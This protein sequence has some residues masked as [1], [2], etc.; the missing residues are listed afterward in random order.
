MRYNVLDTARSPRGLHFRTI[1]NPKPMISDNDEYVI[2]Q[3]GDRLD[4][5]AY[6]FY[7]SPYAWYRIANANDLS[8][9]NVKAGIKLRIPR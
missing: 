3:A 9:L 1:I 2:T 8:L 5:L 7:G 6:Y 4:N